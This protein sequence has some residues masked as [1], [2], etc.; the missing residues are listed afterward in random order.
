MNNDIVNLLIN[1][2]ETIN[3]AEDQTNTLENIIQEISNIY[4]LSARKLYHGSI[5][6]NKSSHKSSKAKNT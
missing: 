4:T 3:I 6:C 2:L 5:E 1:K